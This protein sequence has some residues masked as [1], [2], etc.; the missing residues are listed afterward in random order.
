MRRYI[1]LGLLVANLLIGIASALWSHADKREVPPFRLGVHLLMTGKNTDFPRAAW[2]E[3][4][5]YARQMTGAGG[6]VV[7]VIQSNDLNAEKWQDFLDDCYTLELRP[8]LRLATHLDPQ[9]GYWVAPPKGQYDELATGWGNFFAQLHLPQPLWVI[10]GNE[11]NS[12]GEWGGR[13]DPAAYADYFMAVAAELKRLDQPIYLAMAAL[14]LYA[15]HTNDQPF[16]GSETRLMD[17]AA[18]LDGIFQEQPR[19]MDYVDFWASHPYP[20]GPFSDPPW[21]Q[22]YHFDRI[23]GA[24][25]LPLIHPPAGIYNRGVNGYQWEAWYL[26]NVH[27]IDIPPILI[28]EFGYRHRETVDPRAGDKPVQELDALTIAA[29]LDAVIWGNADPSRS[30]WT[31]L[32]D[33]PKIMGVVYFALAGDPRLWGHSALL[34]VD[35]SGRVL[36]TYPHYDLLGKRSNE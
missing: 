8:V 36:G 19:L 6:W 14:D 10:V 22:A 18:F 35:R 13:A 30:G 9:T 20:M 15:P 23:Q 1:A 11:P 26:K 12:G 27:G 28:S 31:P 4:L 7:Q 29:Y 17:A 34:R 2:G 16:P 3:H 25:R 32:V 33:D 21:E 5:R 24:E